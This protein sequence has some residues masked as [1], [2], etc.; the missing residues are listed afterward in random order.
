MNMEVDPVSSKLVPQIDP[1]ALSLYGL[2]MITQINF[3]Q[4][5]D[6]E[7]SGSP[8]LSDETDKPS[9][10]QNEVLNSKELISEEFVKLKG[11][12]LAAGLIDCPKKNLGLFS[13]SEGLVVMHVR[14]A[15]EFVMKSSRIAWR[16]RGP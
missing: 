15:Y 16:E 12:G 2:R 9:V 4:S 8:S 14:V 13:T 3:K 5:M 1:A 7:P 10:E 6:G 11:D